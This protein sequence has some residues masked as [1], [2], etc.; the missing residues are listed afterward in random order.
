MNALLRN[1]KLIPLSPLFILFRPIISPPRHSV[2]PFLPHL[3]HLCLYISP[4]MSVSLSLSLSFPVSLTDS[5]P[6]VWSMEFI[7]F[8]KFCHDGFFLC[9]AV[10]CAVFFRG[11]G[12]GVCVGGAICFCAWKLW[13]EQRQSDVLMPFVKHSPISDTSSC[14]TVA[15][16]SGCRN[17]LLECS[18]LS[19]RNF[20]G[21]TY[22]FKSNKSHEQEK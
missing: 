12:G 6:S 10:S 13:M 9:R 2:L 4:Y 22:L 18:I 7:L 21:G 8:R 14:S 5:V 1:R 15:G 3:A 19:Q 17:I 11:G 16:E 20:Q